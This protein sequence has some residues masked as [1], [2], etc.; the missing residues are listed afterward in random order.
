MRIRTVK[1]EFYKHGGLFDAERET[2]LPIRLAFSGLWGCADR[3]GRFQ[4][5]PRRLGIEILPYD[6]IDFSRVLDALSTRGFIVK[7]ASG[8]AFYGCI[9][10][11]LKHQVIN[12]RE[13]ASDYPDPALCDAV[14]VELPKT[15]TRVARVTNASVTREVQDSV[16]GK[17]REKEGNTIAAATADRVGVNSESIIEFLRTPRD[18]ADPETPPEGRQEPY[19]P[20]DE[21]PDAGAVPSGKPRNYPFEALCEVS[22]LDHRGLTKGEG[23]KVGKAL[24]GIVGSLCAMGWKGDGAA[25]GA[26]IRRRAKNYRANMPGIALTPTG[27]ENNW[28]RCNVAIPP[29]APEWAEIHKLEFTIG[30]HAAN[31][32]ASGFN[33]SKV[34]REQRDE[35]RALRSRLREIKTVKIEPKKS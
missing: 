2:G 9:P 14:T 34:T 26:E 19:E 8:T 12:N 27:L 3:E 16:E 13:R 21:Q 5:D 25:T 7:Y 22:G 30:R 4:W 15:C 32:E 18:E 10:N 28:G 31:P 23:G 24:Q 6:G 29:K 33:E 1:P 17:G 35:L 20:G 11:F